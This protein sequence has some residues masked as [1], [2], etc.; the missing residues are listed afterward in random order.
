[1]VRQVIAEALAIAE[2]EPETVT[3]IEAHGTGTPLGDPIE[4]AALT[5]A[6]RASTQ[7][8]CAIGSVKT[9]V[10]HLITAAGVAGLIKTVLALKHKSPPSLHFSQPNPKIDFANSPSMLIPRSRNG[11]T[12]GL[13]AGLESVPLGLAPMP[14]LF[15][16]KHLLSRPLE[17]LGPLSCWCYPKPALHSM[18]RRRI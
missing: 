4:I 13:L 3:Y 15:S 5:Q 16:K 8:F 18:P 9:N 11:R 14:M 17:N 12:A 1:M 7:N 10:G 2:V 6:F